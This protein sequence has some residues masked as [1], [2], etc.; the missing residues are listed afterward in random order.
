MQLSH[1]RQCA[2]QLGI[3]Q[4]FFLLL[5]C[6]RAHRPAIDIDDDAGAHDA[7]APVTSLRGTVILPVCGAGSIQLISAM[8][9][10]A[11]LVD[12]V[13]PRA[14]HCL[15]PLE[16]DDPSDALPRE[17]SSSPQAAAA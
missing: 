3:F 1:C 12:E 16:L 10:L 11:L 15:G 6:R 9:A 8:R 17:R 14:E 4:R 2:L 5:W 13:C 7:H